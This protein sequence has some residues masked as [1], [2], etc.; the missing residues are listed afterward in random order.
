[1]LLS[2]V[3]HFVLKLIRDCIFAI[4]RE[5]FLIQ[6]KQRKL[7]STFESEMNGI[8]W[9]FHW[10]L[11]PHK[12]NPKIKVCVDRQR[13]IIIILMRLSKINPLAS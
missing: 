13:L 4:K 9:K 11:G 1:M 8:S 6:N 5:K 10:L 3:A 2:D 7:D 12:D